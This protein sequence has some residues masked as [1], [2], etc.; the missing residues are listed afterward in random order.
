MVHHDIWDYDN[1]TAPMLLTVRRAGKTVDAVAQVGKEGFV[2]VFNRE[3]GVPLWP[4]EERPCHHQKCPA[5]SRGPPSRF[6]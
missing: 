5:R 1:G 4:I 3:T 2:W 6:R